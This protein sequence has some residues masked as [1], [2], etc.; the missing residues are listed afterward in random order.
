MRLSCQQMHYL[1]ETVVGGHGEEAAAVAA[2]GPEVADVAFLLGIRSVEKMAALVLDYEDAAV[3]ELAHE[4]GI[5]PV[6]RG[7]EP[8]GC[9]PAREVAHPEADAG[10]L[11]VDE[12]GALEFL[13]EV[14]AGRGLFEL[15]GLGA[16]VVLAEL[17]G[18][19]VQP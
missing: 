15:A 13:G 5:E 14:T 12:L 16:E 10:E 2:G 11:G 1:V 8:E 4:V 18:A 9:R 6:G 19:F 17:E 3:F 7:L